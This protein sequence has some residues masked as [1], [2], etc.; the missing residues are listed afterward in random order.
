MVITPNSTDMPM[1]IGVVGGARSNAPRNYLDKA[2]RLGEAITEAGR[3]TMT[4]AC[5][6]RHSQ[7]YTE[8]RASGNDFRLRIGIRTNE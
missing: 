2:A 5:S 6:G 4:G 3:V 7:R 1:K 8:S